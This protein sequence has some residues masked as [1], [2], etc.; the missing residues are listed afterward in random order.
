V[1]LNI[2]ASA[3]GAVLTFAL[4][5][6][7]VGK[8]RDF[9][10]FTIVTL[11]GLGIPFSIAR[12][13]AAVI[14]LLETLAA[15]G[16]GAAPYPEP[17]AVLAFAIF[18]AFTMVGLYAALARLSVS[19]GCFGS[20]NLKLGISTASRSAVLAAFAAAYGFAA[21]AG[22]GPDGSVTLLLVGLLVTSKWWFDW[23][24]ASRPL[25]WRRS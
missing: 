15:L 3:L 7:I 4:L 12:P 25:G 1:I 17:V 21:W 14:L 13:A 6:A 9:G 5:L 20:S 19:C 16:L 18:S 11:G 2:A 22:Y 23:K 24:K 10:S 8:I